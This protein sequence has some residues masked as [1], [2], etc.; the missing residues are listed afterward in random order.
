MLTNKYFNKYIK[1]EKTIE[2]LFFDS[3]SGFFHEMADQ[4]DGAFTHYNVPKFIVDGLFD[5]DNLDMT[6]YGK[7]SERW[8]NK[9]AGNSYS[10]DIDGNLVNPSDLGNLVQQTIDY[11]YK[12]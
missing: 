12:K 9:T 10:T 2:D 11:F 3:S 7:Y 6:F 5:P 1:F 8:L 4:D